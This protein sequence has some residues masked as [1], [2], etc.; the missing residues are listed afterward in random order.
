[1]AR[2]VRAIDASMDRAAGNHGEVRLGHQPVGAVAATLPLEVV[3]DPRRVEGAEVGVAHRRLFDRQ[4]VRAVLHE[5]G[6]DEDVRVRG[7]GRVRELPRSSSRPV[8]RL[9]GGIDGI[10]LALVSGVKRCTAS[11]RVSTTAFPIR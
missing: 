5:V 4:D 3:R 7:V 10:A 9:S 1:M 2:L 6:D 11:R 8:A